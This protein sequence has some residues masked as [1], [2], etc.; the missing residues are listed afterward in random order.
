[1]LLFDKISFKVHGEN[2]PLAILL[3]MFGDKAFEALLEQ[4][5]IQFVLWTPNVVFMKTEIPGVHPIA[6]GNLTS[7][8]HSNP[9]ASIELGLN[10]M[11]NKP[12]SRFKRHLVKKI[13]PHYLLPDNKLAGWGQDITKSAF[14]SNK[15]IS[16]GLSP[17][18]NPEKT[19]RR[20]S[21]VSFA[22]VRLSYWNIHS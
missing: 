12:S 8:A 4:D 5:A 21:G 22:T 20:R 3:N 11:K 7:P 19:C 9:E 17:R 1:M 6:S 16:L 13:A 15:L 2:I 10:W 18:T 14:K